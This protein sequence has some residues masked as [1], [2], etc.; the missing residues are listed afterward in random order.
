MEIPNVTDVLPLLI[1]VLLVQFLLLGVGLYDLIKR[2]RTRGPKWV[3][4]LLVIFMGIIG[5]I[6]YLLVGRLEE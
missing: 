3:W 4:Y 6:V 5:P 1:P 2:E